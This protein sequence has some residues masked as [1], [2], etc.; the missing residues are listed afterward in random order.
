MLWLCYLRRDK[1][2][3]PTAGAVS[4]G[5]YRDTEPVAVV[6]AADTASLRTA[7]GETF[8]RGNPAV[9][10]LLRANHPPPVFLKYAGVK[11]WDAFARGTSVWQIE[12]KNGVFQIMPT[13]KSAQGGWV[14]NRAAIKTLP[15]GS[16]VD[17]VVERMV[18]V[19]QDAAQQ[20]TSTS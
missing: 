5:H 8:F 15:V 9:P 20:I 2:Y 18:A 13:Q 4:K 7:L 6:P 17:D 14:V 1:V 3:L 12:E 19:L 16:T 11:T 10:D